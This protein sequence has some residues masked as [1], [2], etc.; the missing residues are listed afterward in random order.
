MNV[1]ELLKE[2]DQLMQDLKDVPA[3]RNKLKQ[4][5]VLIALY[6]D[7]EKV[8]VNGVVPQSTIP[9][10]KGKARKV[11]T[12]PNC[13]NKQHVRGLCNTHYGWYSRYMTNTQEYKTAAKYVLPP[14][15]GPGVTK[16]GK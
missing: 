14:K 1:G 13:H 6:G 5:N 7:D 4:L 2:R 16:N 9:A 3:K 8:S 12:M 10:T 15:T 11:C